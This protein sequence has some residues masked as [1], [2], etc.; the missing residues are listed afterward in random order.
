MGA[1]VG[2]TSCSIVERVAHVVI[3]RPA[4]RNAM[5]R[6]VLDGLAGH[7]EEVAQ[8][9]VEGVVGAVVVAGRGEHLSAGLDLLDLAGLVMSAPDAAEIARVQSIFTAYEELDVPVLA[10]VDGVCFG[11][12]LQLALACHVRAVTERASLAVME[13]R[14][15]LVPDLGASWR[16]PPLVGQGRA[17]ELLLS[18]RRVDAA[19]ALA[20]GLAEVRLD[21]ADALAA[22]HEVALRWA[23]GPEVLRG[24]PRLLREGGRAG[25]A[26]ALAAE[27]A[28]QLRM[29][30]GGDVVEA[31]RAASEGREPRF[32][33]R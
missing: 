32:G 24:L 4:K 19:E 31:L 30:E 25:R 7:A 33:G 1:T 28:L 10:A 15:G 17:T 11:A 2:V 26:E 27:A 22:A 6:A 5:D 20:I 13:P 16:L 23:Q 3:E 9:V 14:W 12:G 8:L 21:G 29:L 18:G